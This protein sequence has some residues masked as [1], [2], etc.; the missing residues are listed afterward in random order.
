MI[1]IDSRTVAMEVGIPKECV[2]SY[3]LNQ[4]PLK[5]DGA[6]ALGS[7][8]AVAGKVHPGD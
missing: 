8:S 6:R 4:L 7:Y 2:T 1:D 3:L 5:M